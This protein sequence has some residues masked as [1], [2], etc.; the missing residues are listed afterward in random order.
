MSLHK[1]SAG[2]GYE[3]LT[4]QVAANDSTE[5]GQDKLE[6]Y[7]SAQG[8]APGRWLGEG[9][10][11][12]DD[13][14][15][16]D[17]VTSEQMKALWGEGR[18]PNAD[19]IEKQLIEHEHSAQY[20]LAATKLGTPFKIYEGAPEFTKA[21]AEAFAAHNQAHGRKSRDAIDPDTRA[22]IRTTV[23]H[24]M[25]AAEFGRN[26]L[27]ERELSGW[28]AQKSRSQTNAV[29]GYD[30][31]FFAREVRVYVVGCGPTRGRGAYR[32][33]ASGGRGQD[34]RLAR[35]RDPLHPYWL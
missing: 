34:S 29:A 15:R 4:R 7:Y 13:I 27:D 35:T 17:L 21:V 8:E 30:L 11:A 25:F 1:L 12:F 23:A 19:Q 26:A 31:T 24:N 2:D 3:Y 18:H 10:A 14:S 28:I 16:G 20:A 33:R 22:Q 5:L 6:S 32:D 9:L